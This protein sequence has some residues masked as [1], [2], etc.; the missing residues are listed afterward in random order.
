MK[1]E[2]T[3]GPQHIAKIPQHVESIHSL[4]EQLGQPS[5]THPQAAEVLGHLLNLPHDI[6]P[7]LLQKTLLISFV[8][9][10][11]ARKTSP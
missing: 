4:P 5:A 9:A 7:E 2:P 1:I 11:R 10:I 8:S 3:Q 6:S